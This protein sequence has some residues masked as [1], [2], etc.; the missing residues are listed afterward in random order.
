[1]D[2]VQSKRAPSCC[3][4]VCFAPDSGPCAALAEKR[5]AGLERDHVLGADEFGPG[6]RVSPLGR[7][8]DQLPTSGVMPWRWKLLRSASGSW[9]NERRAFSVMK[10]DISVWN[11]QRPASV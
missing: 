3:R 10:P 8:A 9:R 11:A 4:Y 5:R 1:M 2:A 7:L 6:L